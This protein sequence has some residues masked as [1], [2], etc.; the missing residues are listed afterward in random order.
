MRTSS[1]QHEF[2][3]NLVDLL[4]EVGIPYMITGSLSSSFH[5]RPRATNDIDI[6]IAPSESDFR[7]FL[8]RAGSGYYLSPGAAWD[9]FRRQGM[10]NVIDGEAGW[11]A[12]LRIRGDRPF[13]VTEFNRRR[14]AAI[15]EIDLWV[16]SPE[17]AVL[18]KLEWAKESASEQQIQDALSVLMVQRESLDE[19][20]LKE[21][22]EA[23]GVLDLLTEL[24]D[25]TAG[26]EQ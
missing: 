16:T 22:A 3:R 12:D 24:L 15:L 19:G 11:K 9:A 17:D 1:E 14:K 18:S 8:D 25:R 4:E 13:S 2:L 5:G 6:V 26:R 10:F 23:L 20:Y 7:A 21:W